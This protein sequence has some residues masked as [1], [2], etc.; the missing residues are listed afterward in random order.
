VEVRTENC[1]PR[2]VAFVRHVGPY[3]NCDVAWKKLNK[4][5][6]QHALISPETLAI[7][8]GHDNPNVTPADKLRY[9]ACITVGEEFQRSDEIG[10]QEI[11]GG[12]YA[13]ATYRGPYSGLPEAYR[14][15][16]QQW[17]PTSGKQM[18]TAPCF[19][20]YVT[21]PRSTSPQDLVTEI[22]V[23]LAG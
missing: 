9:D 1:E 23:P 18:R 12:Q 22:Y 14:W 13:I 5:A 3:E 17:L 15:I 10:V 8:I 19:E 4:F 7:G 16:F 6:E 21:D 11:P 20:V 2:R